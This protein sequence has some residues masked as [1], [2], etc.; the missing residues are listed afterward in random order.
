MRDGMIAF[1]LFGVDIYWY[2]VFYAVSFLGLYGYL[3]WISSPR[4]AQVLDLREETRALIRDKI[5]LILLACFAGV[6]V[7]GRVWAF[8]QMSWSGHVEVNRRDLWRLH[9][10]GMAFVGGVLGV[11]LALTILRRFVLRASRTSFLQFGDIICS[12][13]PVGIILG[14][15]GNILNQELIGKPLTDLPTHVA[16]TL[17]NLGLTRVYDRIDDI[18]R[19]NS[20]LIELVSEGVLTLIVC[21][22]VFWSLYKKKN[23]YPHSHGRVVGVFLVCYAIC[24]FGVEYFKYYRGAR[25]YI[26]DIFSFGQFFMI[27][28]A[29]VGVIMILRSLPSRDHGRT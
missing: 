29:I 11:A 15:R 8:A 2:G 20:N 23:G 25:D 16:T 3:W 17:T 6:I 9:D 27:G 24:R 21:Q 7:G 28:F 22:V 14:R 19:V 18:V 1:S 12:F 13:L 26:L 10:G 5:D 4:M